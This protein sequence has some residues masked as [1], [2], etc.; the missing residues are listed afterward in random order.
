VLWAD[1]DISAATPAN[2]IA[3]TWGWDASNQVLAKAASLGA[4][5]T[6]QSATAGVIVQ[7]W[8]AAGS[9]TTADI[10]AATTGLFVAV[11]ADHYA[12]MAEMMRR[13]QGVAT[14]ADVV[15]I[16]V[17]SFGMNDWNDAGGTVRLT[18]TQYKENLDRA[19]AAAEA[20]LVAAGVPAASITHV[21]QCCHPH[22]NATSQSYIPLYGE[23]CRELAAERSRC[24]G[25]DPTERFTSAQFL[26]ASYYNNGGADNAHLTEAGYRKIADCVVDG[27]L[28]RVAAIG[29]Q[30]AG[31]PVVTITR[32]TGYTHL[33]VERK[34]GAD[35]YLPQT[36][37]P[38]EH[39]D[40]QPDAAW[41]WETQRPY[42]RYIDVN[43]QD[44][45]GYDT[46]ANGSVLRY[47]VRGET[48]EAGVR[49]DSGPW[50]E[51]PE[52]TLARDLVSLP[53]PIGGWLPRAGTPEGRIVMVY[54]RGS[55]AVGPDF[56]TGD[57]NG[58]I[59]WE[60][61][62]TTGVLG[63]L[64]A[65]DPDLPIMINRPWGNEAQPNAAGVWAPVFRRLRDQ[66]D[67][68]EIDT[69]ILNPLD[70][71]ALGQDAAGADGPFRSWAG[72]HQILGRRP[73]YAYVVAQPPTVDVTASGLA[74]GPLL[75]WI[76]AINAV[77]ILDTFGNVP[78]V[79]S[80]TGQPTYSAYAGLFFE[81]S[82]L[83]YYFGE[84]GGSAQ[85]VAE[86]LASYRKFC[87]Y[88]TNDAMFR[89]VNGRYE[90]KPS[91]AACDPK[92]SGRRCGVLLTTNKYAG[93]GWSSGVAGVGTEVAD[94]AERNRIM[95][96][97]AEEL[98]AYDDRMVVFIGNQPVWDPNTA[99]AL[100]DAEVSKIR[101]AVSRYAP[102]RG[103]GRFGRGDARKRPVRT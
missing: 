20:G 87:P 57:T 74:M 16:I 30:A 34:V 11:H 23:A 15:A 65:R 72:L 99:S 96:A 17:W 10:G 75:S 93:S 18:K 80:R 8:H 66:A 3:V 88:A 103:G 54:S 40:S 70:A 63:R 58:E 2:D 1:Y 78:R 101:S 5:I 60:A 6:D 82:S 43:A 22:S 39:D 76:R 100:S 29:G 61:E 98:L 37:V 49:V 94:T 25:F 26:A 89:V 59:D 71:M 81:G 36:P 52:H 35:V 38:L 19:V 91:H 50:E 14:A 27:C 73:R 4:M 102:G 7:P 64:L 86:Y 67:V 62:A 53:T 33:V 51:S 13:Q 79:D 85:Y 42:D 44:R 12:L 48:W 24:T 47:R 45:A 83:P 69:V 46:P 95:R 77:P 56:G 97:R 28:P 32:P 9:T 68:N 41:L 31:L 21:L 90:F 84:I 55:G 92:K